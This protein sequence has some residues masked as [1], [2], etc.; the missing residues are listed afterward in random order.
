MGK[1]WYVPTPSQGGSPRACA[2]AKPHSGEPF[3][4]FG[5]VKAHNPL[6]LQKHVLSISDVKSKCGGTGESFFKGKDHLSA[7]SNSKTS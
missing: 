5:F 1:S 3:N 4:D 2:F 6:Y 7:H